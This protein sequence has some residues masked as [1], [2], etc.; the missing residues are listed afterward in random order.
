M[1]IKTT[2]LKLFRDIYPSYDIFNQKVVTKLQNI[3]SKTNTSFPYLDKSNVFYNYEILYIFLDNKYHDFYGVNSEETTNRLMINAFMHLLPTLYVKTQT[4]KPEVLEMISDPVKLLNNIERKYNEDANNK[5]AETET[6]Y[7]STPDGEMKSGS[8]KVP[9]TKEKNLISRRDATVKLKEVSN[10]LTKLADVSD[11]KISGYVNDFINSIEISS[12]WESDLEGAKVIEV[13]G[14]QGKQGEPGPSYDD[15]EIKQD[16]TEN[17]NEIKTNST[18]IDTITKTLNDTKTD[19]ADEIATRQTTTDDLKKLE[20]IKVEDNLGN[21]ISLI[22]LLRDKL[23][24]N[25]SETI[26]N[27]YSTIQ[28]LSKAI[29]YKDVFPTL[30]AVK[31]ALSDAKDGWYVL[32][33]TS[34]ND[35]Q[36]YIFDESDNQWNRTSI[37][38]DPDWLINYFT[39]DEIRD[40]YYDKTQIDAEFTQHY[41]KNEID[42]QIANIK[43]AIDLINNKTIDDTLLDNLKGSG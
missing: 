4:L 29:I 19:L 33:G 7:S 1:P 41:T 36:G 21:T 13:V 38:F 28:N 17:K 22:T 11:L 9:H 10:L 6:T 26:K 15:S 40:K 2:N 37:L 16:I 8:F 12:L 25:N 39:K 31:S 3:A 42:A 32:V 27:L 34:A 14:P 24:T 5:Y 23:L 43:D 35:Y 18:S 30:D 20:D